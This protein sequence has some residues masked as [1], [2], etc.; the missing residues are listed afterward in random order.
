MI[1]GHEYVAE[2]TG[3]AMINSPR[4]IDIFMNTHEEALQFGRQKI[5]VFIYE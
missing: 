3:G 1:G 2:D 5:E 4:V